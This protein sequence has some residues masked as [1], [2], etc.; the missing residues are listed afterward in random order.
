MSYGLLADIIGVFHALFVVFVVGG[1]GLILAGWA[2]GWT[3]TR[4]RTFRHLHLIAIGFVVLQQWLGRLC[5]LTVWETGLRHR[6]GADGYEGGFIEY[7]LQALLY[8]SA[9]SWVFT[10]VYTLFGAV[11]V[12]SFLY[13]P[14]DKKPPAG[15]ALDG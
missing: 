7:W 8:Y 3:W 1:Q 11:V 12:G 10:A 2:A 9:P 5:P 4:G 6:A 13:Y 14:P 15:S